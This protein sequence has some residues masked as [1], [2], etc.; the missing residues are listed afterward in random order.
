MLRPLFFE[1]EF[2]MLSHHH[3]SISASAV[4]SVVIRIQGG[5]KR[6]ALLASLSGE[7]DP[8]CTYDEATRVHTIRFNAPACGPAKL[9]L[10]AK[11]EAVNFC[12]CTSVCAYYLVIGGV[13][14][15]P[16]EDLPRHVRS[17][18]QSPVQSPVPR[19]VW[20]ADV[21]PRVDKIEAQCLAGV[22]VTGISTS[23][24]TCGRRQ[25]TTTT[26]TLSDGSKKDV[27]ETR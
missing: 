24:M 19:R 21:Q 12:T 1:A 8:I 6:A 14:P 11:P 7:P 26:Y 18:V 20:S 16:P 25:T 23:T 27:T 13:G 22:C 15:A 2:A 10:F 9:V 17:P 3:Q 4:E 5:G